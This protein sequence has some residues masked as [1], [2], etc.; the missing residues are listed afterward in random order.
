MID[1]RFQS[2]NKYRDGMPFI[3]IFQFTFNEWLF[4]IHSC[5]SNIRSANNILGRVKASPK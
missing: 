4:D 3:L 1:E 2:S 5:F